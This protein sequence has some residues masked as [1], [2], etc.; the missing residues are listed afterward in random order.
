MPSPALKQQLEHFLSLPV[1]EIQ[2]YVFR[3]ESPRQLFDLFAKYEAA[4][5]Q[6]MEE[7]K[8]LISPEDGDEI[9]VEFQDGFA[10]WLL[11]RG[12]CPV[13]ARPWVTAAMCRHSGPVIGFSACGGR[14]VVA[15]S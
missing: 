5:R 10:W 2:N 4:W 12:G 11:P 3:A 14:S 7:E 15:M 13:E 6:Q 9:L 1:P 8:S